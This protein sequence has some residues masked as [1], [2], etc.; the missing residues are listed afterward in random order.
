MAAVS[1]QATTYNLENFTGELFNL[2]PA[3]TPFKNLAVQ[4][5]VRREN[6][7]D[8]TWQTTDN[9]T[10]AQPSVLEGAD[11]S[12]EERDRAEVSNVTQIF[13]Y[14]VE[15]SYS[16][17]AATGQ[18]G[19]SAFTGQSDATAILGRQPVTNELEFQQM[20]KLDRCAEDMEVSFLSGTYARP[21]TNAS[22]RGTRG[23]I[24]AIT[25]N[26]V[27]AG[28][29]ALSK[30]HFNELFREMAASRARF[31]RPIIFANAFNIERIS[32]IYGFAPESRTV[33]GVAIEQIIHPLVPGGRI[34]VVYN[35]HIT[36]ST[37]L[38]ADMAWVKPVVTVIPG[39]GELFLEPLAKTGAAEKSQLYGE[40]GLQYGP[41]RYHGTITGTTTS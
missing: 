7:L 14:G 15:V 2:Q 12:Y 25:T 29:T 10:P 5:G 23:I 16:K 8:F 33:G 28:S 21:A 32:E 38:V 26:T 9:T 19:D 37:V 31:V 30:A 34:G 17:L 40:W 3:D 20:L 24:T 27:A 1:G 39:K 41:E 18:L 11:P 6:T 35:R 4:N 36:A 22:A 13:Q